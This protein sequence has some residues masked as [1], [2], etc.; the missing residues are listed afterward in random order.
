MKQVVVLDKE[1]E[2]MIKTLIDL[3]L[4]KLKVA[5]KPT[6]NEREILNQIKDRLDDGLI[7]YE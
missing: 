5:F 1:H 4:T 3:A 6:P 7:I 2:D